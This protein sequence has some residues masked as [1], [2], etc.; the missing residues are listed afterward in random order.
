MKLSFY[1]PIAYDYEY[2]YQAILSYYNIA[3][4]ILLGIDKD[5]I[6]WAGNPYQFNDKDFLDWVDK[7]DLENKISI[8]Q[9]NFHYNR[10][11]LINDTEERN[12]LSR[13][14]TGY[15]IGIDS[16]ELLLNPNE[17][18]DWMNVTNPVD[19]IE[20]T[21]ISVYKSFGDK[22]LITLPNETASI[23]TASV[24]AYTKCR[25]TNKK[26]IKSPL[27]ILHYS[28]GRSRAEVEQKLHN[29]THA[30]DFDVKKH[31]EKWDSITLDNYHTQVNLHPLGLQQWWQKLELIDIREIKDKFYVNI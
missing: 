2:A 1:T 4:E 19:D 26:T 31:L 8:F 30:H 3:D 16:D 21:W 9:S 25:L 22:L 23:G 7:I 6:S 24:Q 29:W 27:R 15:I 20:C 17:F 18:K 13:F 5:K 10:N 12:Y 11:P 28:W 14:C